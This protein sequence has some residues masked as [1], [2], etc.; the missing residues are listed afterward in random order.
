MKKCENCG[1]AADSPFCPECGAPVQGAG[2]RTCGAE[3][4]PGVRY[5]TQCGAP[6]RE[7][8]SATPFWVVGL[9]LLLLGLPVAYWIGLEHGRGATPSAAQPASMTANAPFAAGGAASTGGSPPPLTGTLREQAD[10]LFDRIMRERAAGND[11]QAKFFLP[12]AIQAYQGVEDLDA[13]GH[14]H[15]ALLQIEAGRPAE[16]LA[17]AR[18]TLGREPHNLLALGAAADAA[19]AAGD[20]A[21]ARRD[22][23]TFLGAYA[24]EMARGLPEYSQHGPALEDYRDRARQLTGS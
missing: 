19:L 16:A 3:L 7:G 11:E 5:C 15:L 6:V 2:C 14:F 9:I 1:A 18:E 23:R 20:S 12:M 8:R 4:A 17:T 13:D 22:F 21:S 10:R 24:E